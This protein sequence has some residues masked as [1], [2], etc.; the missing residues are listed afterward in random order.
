MILHYKRR[1][2]CAVLLHS[3]VCVSIRGGGDVELHDCLKL[4]LVAAVLERCVVMVTAEHVGLVVREARAVKAKVVAPLVVG[5]GLA[6]S[7]MS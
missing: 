1:R 2:E 6:H 4:R 7:V 3:L 5:V